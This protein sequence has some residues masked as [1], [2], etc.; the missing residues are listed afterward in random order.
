MFRF[1]AAL[2]MLLTSSAM[3]QVIE[4]PTQYQG[5]TG[6]FITIKPAKLEGSKVRY[7]A[8]DPGLSVFPA[9]LL[10]DPTATVVVSSQP[11]RYRLLA[12]TAKEGIPSLPAY[13]VVVIGQ[14]GPTPPGPGPTPP[15]PDKD[16]LF[17]A[18]SGIY[19]GI[20]DPAKGT[21]AAA[22][23][24]IYSQG[25]SLSKDP[26]MKTAG[27]LLMAFRALSKASLKPEDL[28]PLRDRISEE[29]DRILPLD[30]AVV[31]TDEHRTAAA[32]MCEKISKI[33]E[34]LK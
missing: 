23:A 7:V 14:P 3:A 19:G 9:E 11:G 22:L 34:V 17:S 30:P 13:T 31:L 32:S 1:T 18:L 8:L 25:V 10:T 26:E 28:R 12:Y 16:L 4:L 29:F 20:Q 33:L 24:K 15:P 2:L 5:E 21:K 27:H 6:A